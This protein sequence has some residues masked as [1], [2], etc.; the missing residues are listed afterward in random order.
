MANEVQIPIEIKYQD[1]QSLGRLGND[2][3]RVALSTGEFNKELLTLATT[4]NQA[5]RELKDISAQISQQGFAS[6]EQIQRM[7]QLTKEVK[8]YKDEIKEA[9]NPTKQVTAELDNLGTSSSRLSGVMSAVGGAIKNGIVAGGAAAAAVI[10]ESAAAAV[11]FESSFAGVV[12]TTD[13]L[14]DQFG[15]LTE[16]G[17]QMQAQFRELART[18]PINVNQLNAIGE[19]GGQLGVAR[20]D[21]IS[22]TDTISK[23]DLTTNLN[24]EEAAQT[25]AQFQN[26]MQLTAEDVERSGSAIVALGNNFA[27]TERDILGFTERISGAGAIAELS[28]AD[29]LGISTAFSSVG[30]NAEAGGTA[31]QKVLLEMNDALINGGEKLNIFASAAGLTTD[32]FRQLAESDPAGAFTAF[33]NGL[34]NAGDQASGILEDLELKD[35][36]LIRAFLSLA[37]A[38][39]LLNNAIDTSNAAFAENSA[40]TAEAEVR[41]ATTA[42]KMQLAQNSA[43]DLKITIGQGLTPAMGELAEASI[44]STNALNDFFGRDDVQ[45]YFESFNAGLSGFL[46]NYEADVDAMIQANIAASDSV[47]DLQSTFLNIAAAEDGIEQIDNFGSTVLNTLSLVSPVYG[48]FNVANFFTGDDTAGDGA[49]TVIQELAAVSTSY[50][51]FVDNLQDLREQAAAGGSDLNPFEIT[52]AY[53]ADIRDFFDTYHNEV[54]SLI[55]TYGTAT[56]VQEQFFAPNNAD[57]QI[58]AYAEIEKGIEGTTD[59]ALDYN[60]ASEDALKILEERIKR[61]VNFFNASEDLF[62][63][64]STAEADLVAAQGEYV[65]VTTD[66]AGK[67]AEVNAQLQADLTSEQKKAFS[68]QLSTVEEGT[69]EWLAIYRA[70][71]GD[72]TDSQR[73][74]LIAQRADLEAGNGALSTVYTGDAEAAEEAAQRIIEAE[75]AIVDSYKTTAFEKLLATTGVTEATL[76]Y[77]V[78]I[79]VL[80]EQEAEQRLA[81]TLTNAEL[82]ELVSST[83]FLTATTYNQAEA[84]ALLAGGF[85]TSSEDALSLAAVI[86]GDLS[87]ALRTG[88][89]LTQEQ[90]NLLNELQGKE[91]SAYVNVDFR[92]T[93]SGFVDG[94]GNVVTSTAAGGR[95]VLD[96]I[97]EAD[98]SGENNSPFGA[99]VTII[100]EAN[101][102]ANEDGTAL[103]DAVGALGE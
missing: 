7:D 97:N 32:E 36:Q 73:E 74:A 18:N 100:E 66:N 71:Q 90:I 82:E 72:L 3:S 11:E 54:D 9:V 93:S 20:G 77:G 50:E 21:L 81:Y 103:R 98:G 83:E 78:A 57:A 24:A 38:G 65:T 59:A 2:L 88:A 15:N 56:D 61:E 52:G 30:I 86:D 8:G 6:P 22:F 53:E 29:V 94:N 40:L 43:E 10:K 48:A 96:S 67:I 91:V 63:T 27:T 89:T 76:N 58:Q 75:Q 101:I 84:T 47:E 14:Q 39:D 99:P 95:D 26:V 5:E 79:G 12:K 49:E 35:Q 80:T 19:L 17:E 41:F 87:E 13:G 55:A 31:V 16:T 51:D 62:S 25:L 34:G 69:D 4:A 42:S 45:G 37:N 85:V 33:V 1:T 44:R 28:A 23:L 46:G 68:E 64:I 102:Y 92:S 70:L 60:A